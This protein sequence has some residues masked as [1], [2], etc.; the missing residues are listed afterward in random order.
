LFE[1]V[2]RLDIEDENLSIIIIGINLSHTGRLINCVNTGLLN[3]LEEQ[4]A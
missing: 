4:N 2:T 3:I 1:I